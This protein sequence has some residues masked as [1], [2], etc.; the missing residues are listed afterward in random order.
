MLTPGGQVKLVDFGIA[1]L[2]K[3]GQAKDTQA[4]GTIGYSAPEQYGRGQ[5]DA[6][7]DVYALGV[8]VYQLLTGYDPTATPFRLPPA[9]QA[10]PQVAPAIAAVLTKATE[11]EPERRFPNVGAFRDAL[12]GAGDASR[13][14]AQPAGPPMQGGAIYSRPATQPGVRPGSQPFDLPGSQPFA[15]A[16]ARTTM[17]ANAARWVGIASVA[18]MGLATLLVLIGAVGGDASGP[19]AGFGFLLAF[20]P[21]ASGPAALIMGIIALTRPQTAETLEGRRHT[22][23]GIATGAATLLLCCAI[24]VIAAAAGNAGS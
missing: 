15:G 8:L 20:P 5:T 9:N 12:F 3:P 16:P 6:R 23:L 11:G 24:G 2:F 14:I 17:L 4:F 10:N 7:S 19:L 21:L 22:I 18:L 1:R 13:P